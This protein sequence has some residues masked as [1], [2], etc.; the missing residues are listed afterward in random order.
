MSDWIVMNP[1]ILGGKPCVRG[2]RI[3][4]QFVLE[5]LASGASQED[6]LA[7]Y[8][9]LNEEGLRAAISYAAQAV[10]NDVVWDAKISA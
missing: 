5:L 9:Q 4:V 10:A 7:Q 1:E 6:I 3:S 8:P 2:T